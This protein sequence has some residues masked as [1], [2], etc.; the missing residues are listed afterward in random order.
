MLTIDIHRVVNHVLAQF[1]VVDKGHCIDFQ[2]CLH[3]F[4]DV[5]DIEK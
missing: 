4:A 3:L 1:I 2:R 5:F